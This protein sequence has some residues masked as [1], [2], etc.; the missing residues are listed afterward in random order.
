MFVATRWVC[1]FFFVPPSLSFP[2]DVSAAKS[3]IYFLCLSLCAHRYP[4]MLL[5]VSIWRSSRK[6][7]PTPLRPATV[8]SRDPNLRGSV[9]P[10]A[11]LLVK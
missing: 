2:G 1:F 6:P 7:F 3:D 9:F 5:K 4:N 10:S 8:P 11:A